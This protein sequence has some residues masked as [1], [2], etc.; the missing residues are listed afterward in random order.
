M[1]QDVRLT[2]SSSNTLVA[3]ALV[4]SMLSLALNFF[5]MNR[6][7]ELSATVSLHK[8]QASVASAQS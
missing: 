8:I 4:A 2:N 6:M 7:N 1:E 5:N 3:L